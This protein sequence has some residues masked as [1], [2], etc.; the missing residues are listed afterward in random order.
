MGLIDLN[1]DLGRIFGGLG[2]GIDQPNVVLEAEHSDRFTVSGEKTELVKGLAKRFFDTCHVQDNVTL[3]VK[4]TIQEHTGLGSGTQLAL[5][6]ATALAKLSN[7]NLSTQEFAVAM[8]RCQRT[9]VG[10]T[11]FE[12]GGF[13]VDGG[14]PLK[15]GVPTI[16][17][18]PLIFRQR[19]PETW[20]FVV[21]VPIANKGLANDEEKTAF[22]KLPPMPP[23]TVGKVCRLTMMKLLPAL[24]ECD[25]RNFGEALTK[26]QNTVGDY[27][28][29][30][31]GGRYASAATAETI[32]FMQ[33]HGAYGVGQSSWGP[34]CYGLFPEEEA[35]KAERKVQ[36]F[37]QNS[38]GGQVFTARPNNTGA[39]IKLTK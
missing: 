3:Q 32:Q 38:A 36:A 21:A 33:K 26:I 19:F 30:V 15:N 24:A 10:T 1:G 25:V 14:K 7:V 27:F 35:E 28:A 2:V 4:Q 12:Q 37:L 20:R 9:S 11:I 39:Y 23:E 31:Q 18:P 8:G 13:V 6:V 22:K 5:A 17:F 29:Q 16:D 34:A